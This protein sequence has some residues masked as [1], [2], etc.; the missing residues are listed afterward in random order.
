[1]VGLT[2]CLTRGLSKEE[3]QTVSP[4]FCILRGTGKN[5]SFDL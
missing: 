4:E 3:G 5:S 1:M 2:F